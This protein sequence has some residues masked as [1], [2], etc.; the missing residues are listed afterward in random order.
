MIFC[1]TPLH[2]IPLN[3][4]PIEAMMKDAYYVN[5]KCIYLLCSL[6][7]YNIAP[8]ISLVQNPEEMRQISRM[9]STIYGN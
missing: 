2:N 7:S 3:A 8:N 9:L 6:S 1:P 4:P 5:D